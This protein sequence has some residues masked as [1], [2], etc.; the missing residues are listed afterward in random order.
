MNAGSAWIGARPWA[1]TVL[2]GDT[3]GAAI[4]AARAAWGAVRG[5]RG[6]RAG[7]R[8]GRCAGGAGGGRGAAVAAARS[9]LK[10]IRLSSV[11]RT[12]VMIVAPPGEPSPSSGPPAVRPIVGAALLRRRWRGGRRG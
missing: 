1:F 3:R 9:W 5:G 6:R 7:G 12:V 2:R 11:C 8:A 4:A 10:S